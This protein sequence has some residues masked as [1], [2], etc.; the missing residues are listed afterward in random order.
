VG[1]KLRPGE[2][3][4]FL[5]SDFLVEYVQANMKAILLRF[6]ARVSRKITGQPRQMEL[7]LWTRRPR[8]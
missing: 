5:D 6:W 4:F 1:A 8:R 2:A 3:A 7:N